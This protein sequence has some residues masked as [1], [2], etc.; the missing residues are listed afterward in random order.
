MAVKVLIGTV[1]ELDVEGMLKAVTE[2]GVVSVAAETVKAVILL[3]SSPWFALEEGFQQFVVTVEEHV[4][5][6]KGD[7]LSYTLPYQA[8]LHVYV[9]AAVGAGAVN[10][11]GNAA[12]PPIPPV[13]V[14]VLRA[15]SFMF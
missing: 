11:T 1:S 5:W 9:P 4:V 12:P 10:I 3:I 2:G 8:T 6:K 15:N 7:D 14:P 13:A